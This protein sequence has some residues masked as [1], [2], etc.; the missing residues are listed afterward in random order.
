MLAI[1]SNTL[2][3]NKVC[4]IAMCDN[5]ILETANKKVI[6]TI[7]GDVILDKLTLAINNVS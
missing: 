3:K 5:M 7:K 1:T 6:S 2:G 4:L